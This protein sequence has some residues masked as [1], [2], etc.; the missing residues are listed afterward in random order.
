MASRPTGIWSTWAESRAVG[1][2]GLIIAEATAVEARGRIS[3]ETWASGTTRVAPLARVA[4]FIA[5]GV[6]AGDSA[7]ARRA[8]G[9]YFSALVGDGRGAGGARWLGGC[10]RAE[11]DRVCR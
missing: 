3:P 4:A 11:R 6:G 7:G 10:D 2:A 8:E 9:E 5:D 1:G